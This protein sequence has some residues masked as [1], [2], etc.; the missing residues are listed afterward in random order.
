VYR[1]S[2]LGEKRLG[3]GGHHP[4]PSSAEVK[5]SVELYLFFPS[6]LS[7]PVLW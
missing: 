5:E 2:F 4:S 3:R 6:G 1:V 7:Q